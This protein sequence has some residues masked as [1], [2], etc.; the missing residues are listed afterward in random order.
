MSNIWKWPSPPVLVVQVP[1]DST[2]TISVVGMPREASLPGSVDVVNWSVLQVEF[3]GRVFQMPINATPI[4]RQYTAIDM[5][6]GT[7][8]LLEFPERSPWI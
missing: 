2:V 8:C 5:D 7:E 6:D 3:D 4:G 1:W